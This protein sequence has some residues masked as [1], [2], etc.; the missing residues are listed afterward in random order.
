MLPT[1][2]AFHN[3]N[4]FQKIK[5]NLEKNFMIAILIISWQKSIN[6]G[7]TRKHYRPNKNPS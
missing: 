5:I 1:S 7:I 3:K 6:E 4:Q 2:F